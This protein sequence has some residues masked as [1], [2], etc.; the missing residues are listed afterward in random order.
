VYLAP[1][2]S[3]LQVWDGPLPY[4][5]SIYSV[6][7]WRA[8]VPTASMLDRAL[9]EGVLENGGTASGYLYFQKVRTREG[10]VQERTG[11][12]QPAHQPALIDIRFVGSS[13]GLRG[14]SPYTA[15]TGETSSTRR[16]AASLQTRC[17]GF[18]LTQARWPAPRRLGS[19]SLRQGSGSG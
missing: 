16:N 9:P 11:A 4:G 13:G 2:Y 5:P 1:F 17:R 15:P 14:D 8:S 10:E 7:W 6:F 18:R 12:G 3:R 19:W